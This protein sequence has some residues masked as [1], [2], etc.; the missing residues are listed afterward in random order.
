MLYQ[1]DAHFEKNLDLFDAQDMRLIL[2]Q[3]VKWL[4]AGLTVNHPLVRTLDEIRQAYIRRV[5]VSVYLKQMLKTTEQIN[6]QK[7]ES[8]LDER[9]ESPLDFTDSGAIQGLLK[10]RAY[11][12]KIGLKLNRVFFAN[13]ERAHTQY[14]QTVGAGRYLSQI[15]GE[16][17]ETPVERCAFF[18]TDQWQSPI[19]FA[20][21]VQQSLLSFLRKY[22]RRRPLYLKIVIRTEGDGPNPVWYL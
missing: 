11:C 22:F 16:W 18:L 1:V 17:A 14:I 15:L 6:E 7:A 10:A 13:F 19:D 12:V 20:G 9:E 3:R 8:L 4:A 2:Q 5:G 21:D